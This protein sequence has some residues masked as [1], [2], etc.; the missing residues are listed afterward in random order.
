MRV[1]CILRRV[2]GLVD[3]LRRTLPPHSRFPL[4]FVHVAGGQATLIVKARRYETADLEP[5]ARGIARHRN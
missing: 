4:A 2:N 3:V 1:P 5:L